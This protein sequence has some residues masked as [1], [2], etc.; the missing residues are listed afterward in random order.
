M[1]SS[2]LQ[3]GLSLREKPGRTSLEAK[4]VQKLL[5]RKDSQQVI[6]RLLGTLSLDPETPSSR[7]WESMPGLFYLFYLFRLRIMA[8]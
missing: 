4:Y 7:T 3:L 5:M 8:S 1:R 6:E 2:W